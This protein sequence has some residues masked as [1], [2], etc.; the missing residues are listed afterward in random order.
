MPGDGSGA[1]MDKDLMVMSLYSDLWTPAGL[2]GADVVVAP[3]FMRYGSSGQFS[4]VPAFKRYV[5][6]YLDAFPDLRFAIEDLMAQHGKVMLRYSFTGTHRRTFM[7]VPGTGRHIRAEGVAIYRIER[8][9]LVE[10]WD[11][12]DLFGIA[13]QFGAQLAPVD[14]ECSWK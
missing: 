1:V 3:H 10:M 13:Q 7:G 2:E 12:L 5:A 9:R 4:G 6:H 11:F 14:P 8:G